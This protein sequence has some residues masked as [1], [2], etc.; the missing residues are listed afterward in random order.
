MSSY[1]W[2]LSLASSF[3][4]L[5]STFTPSFRSLILWSTLFFSPFFACSLHVRVVLANWL[6]PLSFP[7]IVLF[8]VDSRII[9]LRLG[10]VRSSAPLQAVLG[11]LAPLATPPVLL[12][13]RR[14]GFALGESRALLS[15]SPSMMELFCS[16][17][18]VH[19]PLP[20]AVCPCYIWAVSFLA[21][22]PPFV[23]PVLLLLVS[24][25][26]PVLGLTV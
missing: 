11:R 5:L 4:C 26:T 21:H 6:L 1:P 19:C 12:V 10:F 7:T 3:L 16:I 9:L 25:P 14:H 15:C 20:G 17:Q 2:P 23:Y 24:L 18:L 22:S 13:I 8:S